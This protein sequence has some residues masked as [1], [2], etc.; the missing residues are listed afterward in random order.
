MHQSIGAVA[1]KELNHNLKSTSHSQA[2]NLGKILEVFDNMNDD[3]D[4]DIFFQQAADLFPPEWNI[5]AKTLCPSGELLI[6]SL[7][8]LPDTVPRKFTSN[9]VCIFPGRPDC[10]DGCSY[11]DQYSV[12]S[13][14]FYRNILQPFAEIMEKNQNNLNGVGSIVS[15]EEKNDKSDGVKHWWKERK[16]IDKLLHSLINDTESQYFSS[17]CI[18]RV[19][20][21]NSENHLVTSCNQSTDEVPSSDG[22][23]SGFEVTNLSAKFE[24]AC[25]TKEI[26]ESDKIIFK[27]RETEELKEYYQKLTVVKL[28]TELEI[29]GI[30]KKQ[31]RKLRKAELI[32][33]LLEQQVKDQS[34]ADDDSTTCNSV[35]GDQLM[36][37]GFH[38]PTIDTSVSPRLEANPNIPDYSTAENSCIL[39]VL[40]ENLQ[41]FPWE[42]MDF[43]SS[44]PIS[45]IPSL[46][47]AIATLLEENQNSMQEGETSD[48]A[49]ESSITPLSFPYINPKETSY[50]LDPE[51]NLTTTK[52]TLFPI[53]ET[54]CTKGGWH[55]HWNGIVGE[56]PALDFLEHAL[57]RNHGLFI[58][59]GHGGGTLSKSQI[60]HLFNDNSASSDR[61]SS[62]SMKNKE[63]FYR[64]RPCKASVLLMG[65]SSG[66]LNSGGSCYKKKKQNN[67]SLSIIDKI[68]EPEGVVTR[69]LLA[70]SPCVVGNLWDVTD[71][72]IDRYTNLLLKNFFQNSIQEDMSKSSSSLSDKRS[73]AQCVADARVACKMRYIVGC[74]P[75]CYGIPISCK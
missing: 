21:G 72:D 18:Q 58:Y 56:V 4:L 39:F 50:V 8:V 49:A 5:V 70:G 31:F 7:K 38:N 74:A 6:A 48:V 9:I 36:M 53:L 64:Q 71:R 11:D 12:T 24:A 60:D 59:C 20:L 32:E 2:C 63:G 33:L 37:Q 27:R 1:R 62:I 13:S 47:F 25:I 54:I 43:L 46:S 73:L 40:D 35:P 52:E 51:S 34:Q 15:G 65:C 45:R 29:Y 42:G 41:E 55:G 69:Y 28:K 23:S 26:V 61:D 14:P 10:I 19:I 16:S 57:K 44:K 3:K 66:K 75:V 17:A 67:S 68:Y 22:S 30:E